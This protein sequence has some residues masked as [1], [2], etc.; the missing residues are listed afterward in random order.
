MFICYH[1]YQLLKRKSLSIFYSIFYSLKKSQLDGTYPF[2]AI[3]NFA[4]SFSQK[5]SFFSGSHHL[6]LYCPSSPSIPWNSDYQSS[7]DHWTCTRGTK[8]N[9]KTE[10]EVKASGYGSEKGIFFFFLSFHLFLRRVLFLC[11][12]LAE[13]NVMS[14]NRAKGHSSDLCPLC[15]CLSHGVI[16]PGKI[17]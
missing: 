8:A 16:S 1:F 5:V 15:P 9:N 14:L 3:V 2:Q 17:S 10:T 13:R 4:S 11:L 7:K 6:Y 12:Y